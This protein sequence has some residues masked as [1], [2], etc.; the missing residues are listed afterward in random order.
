MTPKVVCCVFFVTLTHLHVRAEKYR[1]KAMTAERLLVNYL[2]T[3][4]LVLAVPRRKYSAHYM[5]SR[6]SPAC[7]VL[8]KTS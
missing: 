4:A 1:P 3:G 6:H 7:T 8:R 2:L 5:C